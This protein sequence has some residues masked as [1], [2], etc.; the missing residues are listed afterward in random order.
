MT[1]QINAIA[2]SPEVQQLERKACDAIHYINSNS[3]AFKKALSHTQAKHAD[4]IKA[5]EDK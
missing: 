5:L 1:N 3:E 2:N 4:I